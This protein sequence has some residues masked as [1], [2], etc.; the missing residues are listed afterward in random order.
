[1]LP[2][3]HAYLDGDDEEEDYHLHIVASKPDRDGE[4][5]VVSVST[6]YHFA[7]RTVLIRAGE[8]PWIKHESYVA[9][10]FAKLQKMVDIE[11]RL[12]VRSEMAKE[13]CSEALT[14]RVQEGLLESDQT[15]NG[16]KHFF[17]EVHPSI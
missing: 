15:E 5:I 4:V 11:S 17:R 12:A 9:Y 10:R 8:H 7:D 13:P 6:I 2:C 3:G 16:V 1:M 14:K